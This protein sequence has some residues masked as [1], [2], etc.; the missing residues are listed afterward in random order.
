MPLRTYY[1]IQQ[2]MVYGKFEIVVKEIHIIN[3]YHEV[4]GR[5]NYI[6]VRSY[7]LFGIIYISAKK[8]KFEW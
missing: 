3:R 2:F 7:T 4:S 6:H 8:E 5:E 1:M